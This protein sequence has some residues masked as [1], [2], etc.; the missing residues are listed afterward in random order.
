VIEPKAVLRFHKIHFFSSP[1]EEIMATRKNSL[2]RKLVPTSSIMERSGNREPRRKEAWWCVFL[3]VQGGLEAV[4]GRKV[5]QIDGKKGWI[6][7]AT[8]NIRRTGP[9]A[10]RASIS[11]L[12]FV[13]SLLPLAFNLR[14]INLIRRSSERQ[15]AENGRQQ[16]PE[17]RRWKNP[18]VPGSS[19]LCLT[20]SEDEVVEM[21]FLVVIAAIGYRY[22]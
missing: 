8:I 16:K 19:S 17:T 2:G 6:W 21:L 12:S 22:C 3:S 1:S 9:S 10:P 15:S 13:G 14:L 18:S 7:S 4:K 20:L 5:D 11:R